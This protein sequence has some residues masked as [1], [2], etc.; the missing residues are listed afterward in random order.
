MELNGGGV[1]ARGKKQI[2][3]FVGLLLKIYLYFFVVFFLEQLRILM[4]KL[5]LKKWYLNLQVV[6]V[7]ELRRGSRGEKK[8]RKWRTEMWK[9]KNFNFR[10]SKIIWKNT[11]KKLNSSKTRNRL[12]KSK[13]IKMEWFIRKKWI[14]VTAIT[15]NYQ[16]S[17]NL[18]NSD[19][20]ENLIALIYQL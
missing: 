2:T 6:G 1:R 17:K 10:T 8:K 16:I 4:V 18:N 14:K 20:N 5:H 3:H 11:K 19:L 15:K 9:K 13:T 7:F 12:K